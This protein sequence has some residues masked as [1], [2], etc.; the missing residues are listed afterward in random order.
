LSTAGRFAISGAS[1]W[2]DALA[3]GS[4]V[5]AAVAIAVPV[6]M[7]ATPTRRR[8]AGRREAILDPLR[9]PGGDPGHK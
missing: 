6:A 2:L 5:N 7:N 1:R 8:S 3:L 4:S 9:S